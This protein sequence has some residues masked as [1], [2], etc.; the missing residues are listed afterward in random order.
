MMIWWKIGKGI[1]S[2][3]KA[4]G[5]VTGALLLLLTFSVTCEVFARFV[6]NSPQPVISG[7]STFFFGIAAMLGGGYTLWRRSH[8][9][10]DIVYNMLNE[11]KRSFIDVFLTSVTLFMVVGS[12]IWKG[13]ISWFQAWSMNWRVEGIDVLPLWPLLL[14]VPIGGLLLGG[15]AAIDFVKSTKYAFGGYK[16]KKGS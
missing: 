7:L 1:E 16:S 4:M 13:L 10:M 12:L 9:R 5:Y 8:V 2:I 3:N 14:A 11:R 6:L 15:Q